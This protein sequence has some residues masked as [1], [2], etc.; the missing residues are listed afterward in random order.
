MYRGTGQIS[1]DGLQ[2]F[3]KKRW[4]F[5]LY[6]N[7]VYFRAIERI[8]TQTTMPHNT[9]NYLG[10][11]RNREKNYD[12]S[13][14]MYNLILDA[15]SAGA[16]DIHIEVWQDG[17]THVRLRISGLLH[18]LD[19]F[20]TQ[21]DMARLSRHLKAI[22][23]LD[24]NMVDLPQEG[25]IPPEEEDCG[26][27]LRV[28][29]FPVRH[30]EKIAIRIFN[31]NHQNLETLGLKEDN[32]LAPLQ[33]LL[34]Q[35]SG[36]LL[37]TGPTGSGKTTAIYSALNYLVDKASED[38]ASITK[39]ITTVED[40]VES[41]LFGVSQSEINIPRGFTYARA[42]RS[43]LRQ[44]PQVIMIGEI[45]DRETAE[46]AVHAGLTGHLVISTVHTSSTTGVYAR[47]MDMGI[48]PF[49]LASSISGVLGLR[50]FRPI[51]PICKRP[52]SPNPALM[53]HFPILAESKGPYYTSP[54]D[55]CCSGTG[56]KGYKA[57]TELLLAKSIADGVIKKLDTKSLEE[58]AKK[59][60]LRTLRDNASRRVL[61]GETS[62]DEIARVLG[63]EQ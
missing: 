1:R 31:E 58:M 40:P 2:H 4:L 27:E 48:E 32:N 34:Q 53:E 42:L 63:T 25:H 52:D 23:K 11:L 49:L 39:S 47:L 5:V 54:G 50:L 13:Q 44:D 30:T 24:T 10:S 12:A 57:L 16:S 15:T 37:V 14:L 26:K 38:N 9:K 45:R 21:L 22:A 33:D 18:E 7:Q 35:P 56:Y 19:G 17:K 29:F 60:G 51:C 3:R 59:G 55:S 46:I 28:S 36:L 20:P 6:V 62:L 8:K 61:K 43:L 41:Q